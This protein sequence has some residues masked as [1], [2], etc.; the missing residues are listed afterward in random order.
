MYKK[1]SSPRKH[2]GRLRHRHEENI[3]IDAVDVNV[4]SELNWLKAEGDHAFVTHGHELPVFKKCVT[5]QPAERLQQHD[6]RPP[7][8]MFSV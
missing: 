2:N 1:K 3:T 6:G 5:L 7:R 4:K 8:R